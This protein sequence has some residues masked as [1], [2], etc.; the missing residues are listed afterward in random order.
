MTAPANLIEQQWQDFASVYRVAGAGPTQV[1]ECRRAFYAGA[2]SLF[3]LLLGVSDDGS[4][5]TE[6]NLA[7]L[8]DINAEFQRYADDLENGRA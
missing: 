8:N 2:I 3:H 4:E 6:T 1:R 7:L 5:P